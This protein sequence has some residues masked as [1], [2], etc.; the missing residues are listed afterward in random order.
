MQINKKSRRSTTH[1][2]RKGTIEEPKAPIA[3]SASE[4]TASKRAARGA[5]KTERQDVIERKLRDELEGTGA[6]GRVRDV[7]LR[8]LG[9]ERSPRMEAMIARLQQA[10]TRDTASPYGP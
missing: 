4:K 1:A 9:D 6:P 8:L 2:S 7:V 10:A 3:K 5:A